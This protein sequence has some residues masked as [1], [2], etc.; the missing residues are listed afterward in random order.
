MLTKAI[1]AG[2]KV[3]VGTDLTGSDPEYCANEFSEL[4]RVGMTPMQAIQAG[5]GRAAEALG[6]S[7]EFGTLESGKLADLVAVK[8]DPLSD[9]NLLK[10]V[11]FVMIGGKV[12]KNESK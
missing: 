11:Q 10:K 9:I 1:K 7:K 2:V 12:V 4:V 6:K 5:T 8:G 3:V